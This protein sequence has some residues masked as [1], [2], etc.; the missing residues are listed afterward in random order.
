MDGLLTFSFTMVAAHDGTFRQP[1]GVGIIKFAALAG[2][3]SIGQT[4]PVSSWSSA[5][6]EGGRIKG[7]GRGGAP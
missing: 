2:A 4:T 5:Y 1:A 6:G 3:A 7:G